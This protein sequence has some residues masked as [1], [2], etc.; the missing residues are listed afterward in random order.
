MKEKRGKKSI[1]RRSL[2]PLVWT[3]VLRDRGVSVE[4]FKSRL[5]RERRTHKYDGLSRSYVIM[6]IAYL[7]R[8]FILPRG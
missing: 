7:R 2:V 8:N 4:N 6:C 3:R 5:S 1:T